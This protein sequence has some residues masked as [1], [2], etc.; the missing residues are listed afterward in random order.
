[1]QKQISGGFLKNR[2]TWNFNEKSR[3]NNSG[4]PNSDKIF[5]DF[6]NKLFGYTA[7]KYTKKEPFYCERFVKKE[8]FIVQINLTFLLK[9][10]FYTMR[11]ASFCQLLIYQTA[12]KFLNL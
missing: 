3:S 10:R 11:M 5:P 6:Q 1:M 12:N 9:I 7:L 8:L 2:N 4:H